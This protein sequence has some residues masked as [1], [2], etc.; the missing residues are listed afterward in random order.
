MNEYREFYGLVKIKN[1]YYAV[2]GWTE[3]RKSN[4]IDIF[5]HNLMQ[6]ELKSELNYDLGSTCALE[7]KNMIYATG[8][9]SNAIV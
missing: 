6:W 4:S 8:R 3:G 9:S 1:M 7:Y 5:N 2:L